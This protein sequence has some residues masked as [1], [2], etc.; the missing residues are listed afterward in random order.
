M[1][2]SSVVTKKV[3]ESLQLVLVSSL[4]PLNIFFFYLL[5]A[6][7]ASVALS[8]PCCP[9]SQLLC[10]FSELIVSW[11]SLFACVELN[12]I[13]RLTAV[14]HH[15]I[16]QEL[17]ISNSR[18]FVLFV[19]RPHLLSSVFSLEK[20]DCADKSVWDYNPDYQSQRCDGHS[21]SVV[22]SC[23]VCTDRPLTCCCFDTLH[24]LLAQLDGSKK[25]CLL[26]S[27]CNLFYSC[28]CYQQ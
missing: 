28:S 6:K 17:I 10:H 23:L 26:L 22:L 12:Q 9:A 18:T 13:V 8:Y 19:S 15:N 27:V 24:S 11:N 16:K 4:R 20:S 2:V 1:S 5:P 14:T 25:L 21:R 7:N 3:N